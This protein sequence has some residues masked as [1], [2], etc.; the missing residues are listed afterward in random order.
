M[1]NFGELNEENYFSKSRLMQRCPL[2]YDVTFKVFFVSLNFIL[3]KIMKSF[4]VIFIFLVLVNPIFSKLQI[5]FGNS[6]DYINYP[7]LSIK[8]KVLKDG[9]PIL[10]KNN[11]VLI[12]EGNYPI[13][14]SSVSDFDFTGYQTLNWT[15]SSPDLRYPVFFI[16]IEDETIYTSPTSIKEHPLYKQ[17]ASYIK[18]VDNDRNLVKE[19]K[20][21]KV[22]VGNYTNQRIN[23]V[24]AIQKSSGWSYYPTRVDW[25]GTSSEEF[26]YLWLGSTIN[27]NAPPVDIISPFPYAIEILYI[28]KD[29]NYKREYLTVSY[30]NG[31]K[32]HI[33][34]VANSFPIYKKT[35]LNLLKPTNNEILYPC[36][37]YT[38][39]WKG[40]KA[41]V[42]VQIEYTT[43]KGKVWEN[44]EKITGTNFTWWVPNVETD[45]LFIRL[46]QSFSQPPERAITTQ[47]NQPEK[48]AF[49]KEGTKILSATK[50]GKLTEIDI[51]TK[52]EL[53]TV[54]FANLNY[55]FEQAKIIGLSY[56]KNDSFAIV[57]YRWTDFYGYEKSDTL[58]VVNLA[59]NKIIGI[60][61][62]NEGEKIKKFLTVSSQN[63]V[64][65]FKENQNLLEIYSLPD[66]K[67]V[68][69]LSFGSPIQEI[70]VR[71]NLIAIALLSNKILLYK[72][73]NLSFVKEIEIIYQPYITNLAISNDEKLIAYTTKKDSTKDV[74]E[75]VSDAYI[76]DIQSGQ[77]VRSLY[78]NWSD[79][80]GIEFS[81]TDNY[82]VIGFENNPSI[83]IW[84]L[85]NDVKTAEIF[86]SGYNISDFKVSSESFTIAT[87]EPIRN[88]IIIRD[89][90]FP[91]S[92]IAGPFKIH[93]PKIFTKEIEFPPQKIYYP[94][95]LEIDKNFCNIGDVPLVVHNAYFVFGRNFSLENNPINDTVK[96]GACFPLKIICNPKDTG[97]F[98]DTLVIV[99][100][101]EKYFVPL[102]GKGINR[103]FKFLTDV[104]DFGK[105]CVNENKEIELDLGLNND[106]LQLPVDFVRIFPDGTNY[107]T[108]IEGNKYQ[109]IS[110]NQKLKVKLSFQPRTIGTFS[111]FVEVFYLGQW[112]Y[113]FRIPIKGEGFGIDISL[114]LSDLRF[115]PEI[116]TR[117]ITLKNLSNT[118]IT[119]DSIIFSEQNYFVANTTAP[120]LLPANSA[121]ILSLTM[122]TPPP[123]DITMTLYS[124]PCGVTRTVT[125]GQY[126]GTSSIIFPQ[127]ETEPKGIIELPITFKNTENKPYNGKRFFEAEF[128]LNPNMFLPLDII[129][130]IGSARITKNQIINDRRVVGIAIEGNFPSE[131]ILAKVIGN[132]GLAEF[133]TTLIGLSNDSKFFG[134]NV[135]V[136][137]KNGSIRLIGLC[138]NRRI[139]HNNN[140]IKNIAI[141]PNPVSNEFELVFNA[142]TS[143]LFEAKIIDI[144]GN[145]VFEISI[146]VKE[147][148]NSFHFNNFNFPNGLYKLILT[149]QGITNFVE[150]LVFRY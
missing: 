85:V 141:N 137:Y 132:V 21:G 104:I 80:I 96:I 29:N 147:G 111:S 62:F 24:S 5:E 100:C 107:F 58:V 69:N 133:D 116:P 136:N 76:I 143:G 59:E 97:N 10:V 72:L 54:P 128:T 134:K 25:V 12:L 114:S 94:T 145:I 99:S 52:S 79:A 121:K 55:P 82:V 120:F 38:L 19:V 98:V 146:F 131:G 42:P 34:L 148:N 124:S 68:Q 78:Q 138:G 125:L 46:S 50:D 17:P 91:E 39:L 84:D 74:A 87:A 51:R 108:V 65:L 122:L 3:A 2:F 16:T 9:N 63:K 67:F 140:L 88:L 127:V 92:I 41:E 7:N 30:D 28:P 106:T 20:F 1:L 90:N 6:L 13:A 14:P 35:Q 23:V 142:D 47:A 95:K 43:N 18:F 113:I 109:V 61:S 11:Q 115:I 81:P 123:N 64:L 44:V 75:N 71:N 86:G 33:A 45:S 37:P 32:S 89:F 112:D 70:S 56:V 4:K 15:S 103:E 105:V 102:R 66:L 31:R 40:N 27:Q 149:S 22:S 73:D 57:S 101:G 130:D 135:N 8:I 53:K 48:I 139:T 93:K 26:K 36:Q 150:F 110:K 83:V 117:E 77:I 49:N 129:S 60:L 119:V 126:F 118:D 144:L